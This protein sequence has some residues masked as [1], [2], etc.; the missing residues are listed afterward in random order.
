VRDLLRHDAARTVAAPERVGPYEIVRSLGRGGMGEVFVARRSD[1]AYEREVAIKRLHKGFVS[2]EI[3]GRF[4]RERQMLARLDHE[5]IVRLLDGGTTAAGEPYL[6]MELVDGV[7]ADA[8]AARLALRAKLE[9]FLR[10]TEAVAHAHERGFV[11]RD[12]KPGNILVRADGTPRL[13]DFG[14]ARIESDETAE[15]EGG[16]APLTRAGHRLFTPEYASPEQVRGETATSASDVFALGVLLYRFLTG[17]HPWPAS[18][19]VR[20]LEASICDDDPPTPSRVRGHTTSERIP[21]DLDAIVLCCLAKRPADRY[22]SV[23]ALR[24]DVQNFLDGR[25]IRARRTSFFGRAV[26]R[27]RRRPVHAAALV[28]FVSALAAGG[29]AWRIRHED[30][31]RRAE[32]R[33]AVADRIETAMAR[34]TR[35]ELDAADA[36][37]EAALTSLRELPGEKVLEAEA[38]SRKAVFASQRRAYDEALAH[39]DHA[40]ALLDA[41]NAPEPV[42]VARLLNARTFA[43]QMRS[44]GRRAS[45]PRARRAST[46]WRTCPPVTCC[47]STRSRAGPPNCSARGRADEALSGFEEAV[48]EAR[49]IDDPKRQVTARAL[50]DLAVALAARARFA[51]AGE[52]YDEA[53]GILLW[54]HGES[55]PAV[56][57]VRYNLGTVYF[58]DGRL[59]AAKAQFER[60]LAA[61]RTTEFDVLI[62]ADQHFL[63]RVH[64]DDGNGRPRRA[65]RARPWRCAR[66][67]VRQARWTS[68]AACSRSCSMPARRRTKRARCSRSFWP[69]E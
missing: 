40:F 45:R 5:Y 7:P 31:R 8:F 24:A 44:P 64:R 52:C 16:A 57:I 29:V 68:R 18:E 63:A 50:N 43:L 19:D 38:F 37:I 39:V 56:A 12:L 66:S 49:R 51:D 2:N 62:G 14:I 25:P 17:T 48:S 22:A 53:L 9:L 26:R 33:T 36:E 65:P 59:P 28:L 27:A 34:A 41:V 23:A 4:L 15:R 69:R 42:L 58:R 13:F 10:I 55:H 20:A 35:G 61:A 30:A 21:R 54:I 32:L 11:H 46:R 3:V 6:V 67:S 1:G 60:S 47:A